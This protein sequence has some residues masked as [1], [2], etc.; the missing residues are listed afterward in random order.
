MKRV[1]AILIIACFALVAFKQEKEKGLARV[2]RVDGYYVFI[3]SE[4]LGEYDVLGS[5]KKTGIVISGSPTEMFNTLMK[6]MKKDY[7]K[8]DGIIFQDINMEH[9]TCIQFK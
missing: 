3:Q 7:P 1:L 4:P 2:E 9:A 5:V 6:R 8:A